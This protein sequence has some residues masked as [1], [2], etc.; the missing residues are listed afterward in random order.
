MAASAIRADVDVETV[1]KKALCELLKWARPTLDARLKTDPHFP[2]KTRGGRGGGW[3]FDTSTVLAYLGAA[4]APGPAEA[5]DESDDAQVT[6]P[7]TV[8]HFPPQRMAHTGEATARQL[9]DT[10]DAELKLDRLRRSRGDLVLASDMRE[11]LSTVLVELRSTLNQLPDQ[12]V[13]EFGLSERQGFAIRAKIEGSMRGAVAKLKV[14]L[15][16]GSEPAADA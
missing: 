6:A 13:R 7:D 9:R 3:E 11:V 2:V 12:L 14:Q 1:G 10:A 5:E 4:P 15:G 16:A 8:T